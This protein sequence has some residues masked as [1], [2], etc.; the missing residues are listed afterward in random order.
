MGVSV[1]VPTLE[2]APS[3]PRLLPRLHRALS[4]VGL[5]HEVL[6]VDDSSSDGTAEVA[7]R[8][9]GPLAD[10]L[11]VIVRRGERSLSCSVLDGVR[12][13]AFPYVVVM[14]ADLSHDPAMIGRLIAPLLAD[15][16][17][18]TVASRYMRGGGH[19]TVAVDSA[20][21]EPCRD[22]ARA[23]GDARGGSALGFLRPQDGRPRRPGG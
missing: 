23:V 22:A 13:A 17:D 14:D 5:P 15:E 4:D 10:A 1:V 3:L 9:A 7:R 21:L 18:L 16:A 20:G 6:I 8:S 11:R 12:E 2:E 19:R